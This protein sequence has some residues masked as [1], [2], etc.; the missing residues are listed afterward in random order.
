MKFNQALHLL[1]I[2]QQILQ[3]Y[4]A[5]VLFY[6]SIINFGEPVI[7]AILLHLILDDIVSLIARTKHSKLRVQDALDANNYS[8]IASNKNRV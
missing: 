7:N 2:I 1:V 8:R 6:Y 5:F 3:N 4:I